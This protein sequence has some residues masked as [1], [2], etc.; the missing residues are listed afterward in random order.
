MP[1]SHKKNMSD[2]TVGTCIGTTMGSVQTVE[3]INELIVL[4]QQR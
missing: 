2:V 3:I 1:V 4:R